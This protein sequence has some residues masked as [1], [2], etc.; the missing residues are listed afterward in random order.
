MAHPQISASAQRARL[1]Q[2]LKKRNLTTLQARREI[3]VLLVAARVMELRRIGHKIDTVWT[4]DVTTEGHPHR[5]AKYVFH[6]AV[7]GAK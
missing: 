3:D 4:R 6:T 1:L 7:G 2:T 5:V